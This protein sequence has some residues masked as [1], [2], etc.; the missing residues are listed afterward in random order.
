MNDREINAKY[1]ELRELEH[2][3]KWFSEK[4][5]EDNSTTTLEI[6]GNYHGQVNNLAAWLHSIA[7]CAHVMESMKLSVVQ[8]G[9]ITEIPIVISPMMRCKKCGYER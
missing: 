3:A 6:A 4:A 2:K 1:D 7:W 5:Y 8:A 9:V